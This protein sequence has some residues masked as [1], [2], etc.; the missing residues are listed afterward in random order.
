MHCL[1]TVREQSISVAFG[2][3]AW[4]RSK[5]YQTNLILGGKG[6]ILILTYHGGRFGLPMVRLTSL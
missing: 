5:I 1:N 2:Q 4:K 3:D 6:S